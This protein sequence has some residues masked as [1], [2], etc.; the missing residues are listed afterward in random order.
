MEA[1]TSTGITH[2]PLLPFHYPESRHMK[3]AAKWVKIRTHVV[4]H[5]LAGKK[6]LKSDPLA[7]KST[8]EV[9]VPTVIHGR[10]SLR[11]TRLISTIPFGKYAIAEEQ[12]KTREN[13]LIDPVNWRLAALEAGVPAGITG[14][15]LA[16]EFLIPW[17]AYHL[18]IADC[19]KYNIA[20]NEIRDNGG[21]FLAS[22]LAMNSGITAPINPE[23]TL[24]MATQSYGKL[25]NLYRKGYNL[26]DAIQ[27]EASKFTA[28]LARETGET[29]LPR[30]LFI[31]IDMFAVPARYFDQ[32]TQD[33]EIRPKTESFTTEPYAMTGTFTANNL[34]S[35]VFTKFQNKFN[36]DYKRLVPVR[37]IIRALY[38]PDKPDIEYLGAGTRRNCLLSVIEDVIAHGERTGPPTDIKFTNDLEF[39][40]A[41]DGSPVKHFQFDRL[42]RATN[43]AIAIYSPYARD[44]WGLGARE[45]E[46]W[47]LYGTTHKTAVRICA[48]SH[49]ATLFHVGGKV[50]KSNVHFAGALPLEPRDGFHIE[51]GIDTQDTRY[52][53]NAI[54]A[55]N[56]DFRVIERIKSYSND[57]VA[58]ETIIGYFRGNIS[59]IHMYNSFDV[60]GELSA[61]FGEFAGEFANS[62][63]NIIEKAKEGKFARV[64]TVQALILKIMRIVCRIDV[65]RCPQVRETIR[66]SCF[67]VGSGRIIP[68]VKPR[69]AIDHNASYPSFQRSA[70]YIG[71]PSGCMIWQE[72][73][74][75]GTRAATEYLDS[76]KLVPA[77]VIP[78]SIVWG[79][80]AMMA[81]AVFGDN[82]PAVIPLPLYR[83]FVDAGAV[84]ELEG[85]LYAY[86]HHVDYMDF[87]RRA[88]VGGKF[89]RN[90]L[91]GSSIAGGIHPQ[92]TR[93]Y[94]NL[95]LEDVGQMINEARVNG[96]SALYEPSM[97]K[98]NVRHKLTISGP[99]VKEFQLLHFY[100]YVVGYSAATIVDKWAALE[101]AGSRVIAYN[102]DCLYLDAAPPGFVGSIE[103]GEW[104]SASIISK[105]TFLVIAPKE[106]YAIARDDATYIGYPLPEHRFISER[107]T[108]IEAPAGIG[109]SYPFVE[110]CEDTNIKI[111]VPRR[112]QAADQK[113]KGGN[114]F[115]LDAIATNLFKSK[116]ADFSVI[117][118][119][120]APQR[121]ISELVLWSNSTP[122]IV[123]ALGDT[124]QVSE[125]IGI[126]PDTVIAAYDDHLAGERFTL[127]ASG[128]G[129]AKRLLALIEGETNEN[130]ALIVEQFNKDNIVRKE[131]I[132]A[133]GYSYY[134]IARVPGAPARHEFDYGMYLDQYRHKPASIAREM[135]LLND[136]FQNCTL[137]EAIAHATHLMVD[138]HKRGHFINARALEYYRREGRA[139]PVKCMRKGPNAGKIIML[140]PEHFGNIDM[141]QLKCQD[142]IA[143][144]K[145]W[146][147]ALAQTVDSLQGRTMAADELIA[148]DVKN[149]TRENCLYTAI[150]RARTPAGIILITE[151]G[152]MTPEEIPDI[153][154]SRAFWLAR[155]AEQARG[156][157]SHPF[158]PAPLSG[159]SS[160]L[161]EPGAKLA[162][163]QPLGRESFIIR[164]DASSRF[165]TFDS[166]EAYLSKYLPELE[167]GRAIH[168]EIIREGPQRVKLDIDGGTLADHDFIMREFDALLREQI[169]SLPDYYGQ[170]HEPQI[171]RMDSTALA[172]PNSKVSCHVVVGNIIIPGSAHMKH[173]AKLLRGR[174]GG[175]SGLIDDTAK[176]NQNFRMPLSTSSKGR[177]L[178]PR[179]GMLYAD[180]LGT[181]CEG[182][183][184]YKIAFPESDIATSPAG[185]EGRN[186]L[187]KGVPIDEDIEKLMKLIPTDFQFR[188]LTGGIIDLTRIRPSFCK[189]CQK[190]H[191]AENPY[192]VRIAG[193]W[194]FCCRRSTRIALSS[195][196]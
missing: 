37:L 187:A 149:I 135:A 141:S 45:F 158:A 22:V 41:N 189:K 46:P 167:A 114:T 163:V 133:A 126:D 58:Y 136:E 48:Q 28:L 151:D 170:N 55:D 73:R 9:L 125:H 30:N 56:P 123:I 182:F 90:A 166:V 60:V 52:K 3:A 116:G 150:T 93:V 78:R 66:R 194:Y 14:K 148:I 105:K 120:E 17:L 191:E 138:N 59:E 80:A 83:A 95:A 129:C 12:I 53:L 26:A 112:E 144:G 165:E 181:V 172:G 68:D 113:T 19:E 108:F 51:T 186:S 109:K 153:I 121:S 39:L 128:K 130:I 8:Y 61:R 98:E 70:R 196:F 72:F 161:Y 6:I 42:A 193:E 107:L 184:G 54:A 117:V 57:W 142:R 137:N 134:E 82:A 169:A 173:L 176:P 131:T 97:H 47:S 103:P 190:I 118:V 91:I 122:M 140:G 77:F 100:S 62:Y 104:K 195:A 23:C 74:D 94:D 185:F 40:N 85:A 132:I 89:E 99:I 175:L 106:D 29:E 43:T 84:F 96:D 75:I 177:M 44:F 7:Y 34:A 5:N 10:S 24:E 27:V 171:Y 81:R 139:F 35:E 69:F 20:R 31:V 178:I 38:I 157:E 124:A 111:G 67:C 50:P 102:R 64:S 36:N 119:D 21:D 2:T 1:S 76:G 168:H 15:A 192:I 145:E 101:A 65:I 25:C 11:K 92:M 188:G 4:Y 160:H 159:K 13:Y 180:L 183:R 16:P 33:A 127:G 152:E 63:P 164:H 110:R 155:V 87:C 49:H 147:P 179:S 162:D 115:T 32:V 143:P 86:M 154:A 79:R 174:V 156:G 71:I 18:N 88:H 146:R